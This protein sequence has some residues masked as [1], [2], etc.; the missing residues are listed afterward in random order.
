MIHPPQSIDELLT[1]AQQLAGFT[2][3]E[4][5]HNAGIA[6]PCDPKREKGWSGQLIERLLGAQAGSKPMQDFPE[7]AVELKTLP[8]N[9]HGRP[10][11]S[12]YVCI[13]PLR[14]LH[15]QQWE[16]S[17]VRNK[18]SCVLW[19]PIVAERTIPIEQRIVCTPFLWRPSSS[20]LETLQ[21]DWEEIIEQIALGH[22]DAIKAHHGQALQ[23]R[24]K[25]ANNRARTLAMGPSGTLIETLPRGFYLRSQFTQQLLNEYFML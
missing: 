15:L 18:L 13:T 9:S 16:T 20:Q 22:I 23:L 19:V 7:L 24:P 14:D 2:L 6:M 12:T 8:I 1:R 11:E 4:L 5:A 21:T 10:L 17:N 3:A 25:A